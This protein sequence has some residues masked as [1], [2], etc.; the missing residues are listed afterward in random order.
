MLKAADNFPVPYVRETMTGWLEV[1]IH[2]FGGVNRQYEPSM[3]CDGC[4]N[5]LQFFR[6]PDVV[7]ITKRN[8]IAIC[9][10]CRLHEVIG[11]AEAL[12]ILVN[13]YREGRMGRKLFKDADSAIS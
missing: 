12:I 4:K 11:I 6:E 9:Q 1:F 2:E 8:P 10:A 7:L 5:S 3:L 13:P